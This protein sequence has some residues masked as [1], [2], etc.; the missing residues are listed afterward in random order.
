M[1]VAQWLFYANSARFAAA[2]GGADYGTF[3]NGR[4]HLSRNLREMHDWLQVRTAPQV[5]R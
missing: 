3:A 2:M 1:W 5:G 4:W